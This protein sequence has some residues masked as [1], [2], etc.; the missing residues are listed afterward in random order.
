[1]NQTTDNF[2]SAIGVWQQAETPAAAVSYRLYYNEQGSPV[3]Y[4]MED[5]PGQFVEITAKQFARSDSHVTVRD[6]AIHAT[7]APR[8]L[9]LIPA[10]H[11]T[12]CAVHDVSIVVDSQQP[13]LTWKLSNQT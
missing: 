9:Q 12:P 4:T 2:I 10:A 13:H 1:M 8:P 3:C 11:G 6:G 5:L 7:P